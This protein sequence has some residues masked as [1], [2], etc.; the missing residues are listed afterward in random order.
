[1]E[2]MVGVTAKPCLKMVKWSVM[3]S[4][5]ALQDNTLRNIDSY[6]RRLQG[7]YKLEPQ[8]KKELYYVAD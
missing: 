5:K 1:M 7:D 8:N 6:P 4:R 2:I 3:N